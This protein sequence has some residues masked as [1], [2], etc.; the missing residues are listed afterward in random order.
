MPK[1]R[2]IVYFHLTY[3]NRD[4]NNGCDSDGDSDKSIDAIEFLTETEVIYSK[5]GDPDE[6]G[7]HLLS[8]LSSPMRKNIEE[9]ELFLY[10]RRISRDNCCVYG[11]KLFN[12][13]SMNIHY[14]YHVS[15]DVETNKVIKVS[16]DSLINT[17]KL[18]MVF[19]DFFEAIDQYL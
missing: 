3:N 17:S 18:K 13:T 19:P 16:L 2:G 7:S 8:F 9:F 6:L 4:Y 5:Y 14:I 10:Q 12:T 15:I 11:S 1:R